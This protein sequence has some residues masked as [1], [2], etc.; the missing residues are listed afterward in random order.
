LGRDF[1]R[2][3]T[4]AQ[5]QAQAIP[6]WICGEQGDSWIG[7]YPHVSIYLFIYLSVTD[8]K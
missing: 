2:F 3:T 6:Y 5:L 1:K 8:A 4:D 7:F